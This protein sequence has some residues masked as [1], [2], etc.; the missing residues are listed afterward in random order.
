MFGIKATRQ[1]FICQGKTLRDTD[2]FMGEGISHG[3]A[4][5][6][7][8]RSVALSE[9][10]TQDALA[11]TCRHCENPRPQFSIRYLCYRCK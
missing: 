7:T 8:K 3:T 5:H 11:F 2:T 6:V 4:V 10:I 1:M 9:V